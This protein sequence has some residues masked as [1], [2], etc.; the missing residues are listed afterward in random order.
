MLAVAHQVAAFAF[1]SKAAQ[2]DAEVGQVR[3]LLT[4]R[5]SEIR[6]LERRCD[7][8]EAEARILLLSY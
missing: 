5:Q 7:Q 1:A 6:A 8:L 4:Q 3:S 2:G